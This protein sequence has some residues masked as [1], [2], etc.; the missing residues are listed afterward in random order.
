MAVKIKRGSDKKFMIKLRHPNGDPYSELDQSVQVTVKL[1]KK[2]GTKISITLD[3]IAAVKASGTYAEVLYTAVVA[4]KNGNTIVLPFDGVKTIAQVISDW[5]TAN[6]ANTVGS[7]AAD[8]SVVPAAGSLTLSGGSDQYNKVA[9]VAP[10]VLG[11]LLIT[12][13]NAD[14]A[15]LRFGNEQALEVLV[16]FGTDPAVDD[17]GLVIPN[18]IDVV[19]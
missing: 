5:N 14:T 13:P 11:K 2:D 9:K 19:D 6:P 15:Q 7:N 3:A 8:T 10:A 16:E 17:A 12:L 4:G 1:P 18:A